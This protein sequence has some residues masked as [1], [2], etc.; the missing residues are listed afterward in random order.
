MSMILKKFLKTQHF[1]QEY[2]SDTGNKTFLIIIHIN[3]KIR[4][5]TFLSIHSY[6]E[7][8]KTIP[9]RIIEMKP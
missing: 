3:L 2:F 5:T 6:T 1:K 8:C 7:A 4:E 9:I